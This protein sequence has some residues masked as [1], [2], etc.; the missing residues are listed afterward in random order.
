MLQK[1]TILWRTRHWYR[2][3][4]LL[5]THSWLATIVVNKFTLSMWIGHE[6]KTESTDVFVSIRYL[7]LS[8]KLTDSMFT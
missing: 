1:P 6:T 7:Y 4:T 2:L 8:T 3:D 5:H